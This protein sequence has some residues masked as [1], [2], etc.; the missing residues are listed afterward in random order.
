MIRSAHR[1]A[2]AISQLPGP[3]RLTPSFPF[4]GRA[5]ELETLR[6]LLPRGEEDE[7][8]V[9]VVSGEE[10]AGKSRIVR[11]LA[12][13]AASSDVLVLY[14][15][16]DAVVR[17]PYEPVVSALEQLVRVTEPDV[18]RA[19]LGTTGGELTRLIP[20]LG[21]RVGGLP[22]PT[23]ADPDS[24]R[25]QLFTAVAELLARVSARHPLLVIVEDIHWADPSTLLLLGYLARSTVA[26]RML[27]VAT[28]RDTASELSDA[29]SRT[30]V[31]LRRVEGVARVRLEG[32]KDDEV[33]E[34]V[35]RAAGVDPDTNLTELARSIGSVTDGN[36]FLMAESWRALVET[37]ALADGTLTRSIR[38]L[39]APDSLRDVVR[40]RLSRLAEP[41]VDVLDL[42]AVA[43]ADFSLDVVRRAAALDEPGFLTALDEAARSGMIEEVPSAEP[44]YRF[45]HELVRR[46]LYDRL[47]GLR[48]AELHLRVGTA[49]ET[50]LEGTPRRALADLAHHFAAAGSLDESD[51][52]LDY[53]LQAA[54][55][56]V[57]ALAFDQAAAH[58]QTA[59][60]VGSDGT[61]E[62]AEIWLELGKAC[63]Q[64]SD[65][66]R[67]LDA[68]S[69]A[70]E[71]ATARGDAQLLARAAIGFE[72]ACHTP[73]ITDRRA[74]EL[75]ENAASALGEG[76]SE[77]RVGI[78]SGL[79]R[80]LAFHGEDERAAIVR[81]SA[82]EM[83]R[84]LGD[85][86]GLAILLARAY[87]A[88][89]RNTL[90]EIVDMLTEARDLA[91]ELGDVKLQSEARAW[92]AVARMASGELPRARRELAAW[93]DMAARTGE[94]FQ[95]H[96]AEFIA[97]AMA[98]A[99]GRLD[100]AEARALRALDWENSVPGR[101]PWGV[102]GIQMFS[103][104]REQGRL[105]ELAPTLRVLAGADGVGRAWRP[106]LAA[107]LA[108]L[109]MEEEA[110]RE[111]ALVRREG[112][113]PFRDPLWL[114]S[115]TYLSD[116]AAAVGD[117]EVAEAVRAELEPFAGAVVVVGHGVAFYGA[118]DRYLGMLDA[119]LRDWDRAE[120]H[121]ASALELNQRMGAA[122]WEA[123]TAHAY[124]RML[125]ARGRPED[126]ERSASLLASATEL[127]ERIG[128]HSLLER[129]AAPMAAGSAD[130][131][132]D[133]LSPR[134]AEILRLVAR[135]LSNRGI[136]EELYI[137]EHT[138][139]NHV[140]SILSKTSC[141]NRTEAAT[142][143]H[144]HGL[145]ESPGHE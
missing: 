137:S 71:I 64:A 62:R 58:F 83:A 129:I 99:A 111:L 130:T 25:H 78:L 117:E 31:A 52:A 141:A 40:E 135:G 75:L 43:G 50:A 125:L 2:C 139:A 37:G 53:N 120:A 85:R 97:S 46:A 69:A 89:G 84:R 11:E 70:A 73:V 7:T 144:Q 133:G 86:R 118:T 12:H 60:A 49:L 23:S 68:F 21:A 48:R 45:T 1:G 119:T 112:L 20:D 94:P 113:V 104:R 14:G 55:S 41:T 123:H 4:V 136:G 80:E 44:A 67:A 140:R 5:R 34:F 90:E 42:A 47:D 66:A 128:M 96:A 82:T 8:R 116:A 15:A 33:A 103:I 76:A 9:A 142:Y 124:G 98:L 13:E 27:L 6:A 107:L 72:G 108:E 81:A 54:R 35:H 38:D 10:G 109:G 74:L 143:A 17:A 126:A 114:T 30:L 105:G 132:P 36:P 16:C 134:E 127:A 92:L 87:W 131:L 110:R 91:D 19:D 88:R 101:D 63:H 65:G 56:A 32:L 3:L 24:E 106:G 18:L 22:D 57:A 59:L 115:L 93:L 51:R 39:T 28:F 100:E 121:F 61:P 95:R 102:H 29:V 77:L 26:A 145:A 138:A 79:A 122:T